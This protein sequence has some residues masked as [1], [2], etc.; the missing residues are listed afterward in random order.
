ML[1]LT[2]KPF[3][4]TN[5][6]AC[7]SPVEGLYKNLALEVNRLDAVPLVADANKGNKLLAVAV[8]LVIAAPPTEANAVPL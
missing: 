4:A 2:T 8:S 6:L 7:N 5:A 3:D 1:E